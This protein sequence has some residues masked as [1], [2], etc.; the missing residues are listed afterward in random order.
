MKVGVHSFVRNT[1]PLRSGERRGGN[2]PAY[3]KPSGVGWDRRK[4]EVVLMV[5]LKRSTTESKGRASRRFRNE[6]VWGGKGIGIR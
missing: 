5:P 6:T 1:V 4:K 3:V 2:D